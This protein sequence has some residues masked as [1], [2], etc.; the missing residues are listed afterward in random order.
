MRSP[1]LET[2]NRVY[3]TWGNI[4][5]N[6]NNN[7]NNNNDNNSRARPR[8]MMSP[9]GSEPREPGKAGNGMGCWLR[10]Q[11]GKWEA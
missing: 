3:G 6:E 9:F 2:E 8:A 11:S 10:R 7:N 1:E 5:N 4:N